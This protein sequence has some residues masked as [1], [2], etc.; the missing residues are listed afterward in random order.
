MLN[1]TLQVLL[2]DFTTYETLGVKD[3]VGRIRVECI[4]GRVADPGSRVRRGGGG[5]R[6]KGRTNSRSSSVNETHEG[7]IRWP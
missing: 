2:F 3:C 5:V 6:T 7:V 1:V 4:L